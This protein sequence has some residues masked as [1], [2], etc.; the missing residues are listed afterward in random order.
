[1]QLSQGQ[2]GGMSSVPHSVISYSALKL[3]ALPAKGKFGEP[4]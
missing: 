3:L 1:M 2:S 4:A